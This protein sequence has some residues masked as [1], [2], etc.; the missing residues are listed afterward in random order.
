MDRDKLLGPPDG[1]ASK[2]GRPIAGGSG[3]WL[4]AILLAATFMLAAT[5]FY[6]LGQRSI[7]P[8]TTQ[9][10]ATPKKVEAP[11]VVPFAPTDVVVAPAKQ[12]SP[13][14]NLSPIADSDWNKLGMGCACTF[15]VA[16][17]A[18]FVTGGDDKAIFRPNGNRKVCAIGSEQFT[19]LYENNEGRIECGGARISIKGTG[20]ITPGF[21]GHG[22]ASRMTVLDGG[23]EITLSG[24]WNCG[25]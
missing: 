10:I 6:L 5:V 16:K 13:K 14:L 20:K 18:V 12:E 3:K 11:P 17:K 19:Q 23:Q 1:Q 8:T 4:I 9:V 24:K 2:A 15:E 22:T 7:E 25:C 21:D